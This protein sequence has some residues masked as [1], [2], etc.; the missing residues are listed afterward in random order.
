MQ[1]ANPCPLLLKVLKTIM[2]N[3]Q[4]TTI[5]EIVNNFYSLSPKYRTKYL[6]K[7]EIEQMLEWLENSLP[8]EGTVDEYKVVGDILKNIQKLK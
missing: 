1:G 5:E 4:P 2:T 7:K 6:L 8:E 3:N